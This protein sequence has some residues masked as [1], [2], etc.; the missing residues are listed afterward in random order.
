MTDVFN[1]IYNEDC[2]LGLNRIPNGSVDLVVMDP[3]YEMDNAGGGAFGSMT[4]LYHAKLDDL[5]HGITNAFLDKLVPKFKDGKIN[6]YVWCNKNQIR[7]YIDY[8]GDKDCLFDMLTWHKTN[9]VP[10][11]SNKYL[12][13]TEYCCFFRSKGVRV[14]GNYETKKKYYVT[15]LNVEDKKLWDHPTIK[16]LPIIKNLITN[17]IPE[18]GCGAVVLDPFIG[19]GTTAVAAKELGCKY[20]GFEINPDYYET[21]KKRIALAMEYSGTTPTPVAETENKQK[22]LDDML[23]V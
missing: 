7:Q 18:P 9:P 21:A 23:S 1:A 6:L 15:P 17:S 2:M 10:A 8:F 3:P 22:T 16:P 13:D 12:S 11:C 4:K 20:I 19:S 14:Y 5:R